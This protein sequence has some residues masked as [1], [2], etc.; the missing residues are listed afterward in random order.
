M[1]VKIN[2]GSTLDQLNLTPMIDLVFNLLIFFMVATEFSKEENEL[3][4]QLP[5]ASEAMPITMKPKEIFVNIN[6]KGQYYMNNKIV[7]EDEVETY[8][9]RAVRNNPVSQSVIIRADERV[10]FS[11]VVKVMDLCNRAEVTDYTVST[12]GKD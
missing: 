12:E 1:A 8:L 2:K 6:A 9:I 4:V 5:A 3:K 10:P 11:A 7:S